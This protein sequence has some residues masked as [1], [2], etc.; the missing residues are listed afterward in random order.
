MKSVQMHAK[1]NIWA[2]NVQLCLSLELCNLLLGQPSNGK[3]FAKTTYEG[4][5]IKHLQLPNLFEF[6]I[7]GPV[8]VTWQRKMLLG[9]LDE[10]GIT[11]PLG[12]LGCLGKIAAE[13][14]ASLAKRL[15]PPFVCRSGKCI[16]NPHQ[17]RRDIVKLYPPTRLQI[18]KSLLNDRLCVIEASY[19]E[20][21][22]D[23]VK[24]VS[25]V[26]FFTLCVLLHK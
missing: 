23:V 6:R 18:V 10:T 25:K 8:R 24:F 9:N 17:I 20:S 7:L 16:I 1:M 13:Y 2:L 3:K 12:V 21:Q 26:P 14:L 22:V 4:Q 19:N 15:R 5:L 11:A